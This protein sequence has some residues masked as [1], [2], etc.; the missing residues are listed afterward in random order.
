M[1]GATEKL[2]SVLSWAGIKLD[3]GKY[4]WIM[5]ECYLYLCLGP[6]VGGAHGPYVQSKRTDIYREHARKLVEV[7]KA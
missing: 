1:P 5:K 6:D 3:E 7:S 2:I 4:M